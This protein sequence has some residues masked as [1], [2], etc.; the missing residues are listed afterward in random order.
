VARR[1]SGTSTLVALAAFAA[2]TPFGEAAPP[3][4]QFL[5]CHGVKIH[6][7][8]AGTGEPVILI[9]GL[10]SSAAINWQLTGVFAELAKDHEVI[11]LD[12]PGHG[13]SDKPANESAYGLAIVGD[14]VAL[15]DHLKVKRAHVV[16]YSL[17]GMIA[18]KFL[19]LHPERTKS[20]LIGGMG[21]FRAGSPLQK[22][23]GRIPERE[24]QVV[25]SAFLQKVGEFA[26]SGEELKKIAVPVE[27]IVGEKDPVKPLYVAALR[28][29]R[30]D[31][32]IVEIEGA[33]HLDCIVK[34]DFRAQIA[35][36]LH[37][38]GKQSR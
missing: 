22:F 24:K 29:A 31:W 10:Y 19:A 34:P 14:I 28:R 7:V 36:W 33:G 23:W 21:W 1:I 26:V 30:P 38:Q 27:V 16:G 37:K 35:S 25:P 11:A 20:G 8:V 18:V 15:L 4:S 13:R 2:T 3:K 6:Y 12:L 17:G 5:D 32:P 9:H